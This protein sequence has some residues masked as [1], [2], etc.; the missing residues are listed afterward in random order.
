[1]IFNHLLMFEGQK[2][3][4]NHGNFFLQ[5]ESMYQCMYSIVMRLHKLF[6]ISIPEIFSK[7]YPEYPETNP[8][9]IECSINS[10]KTWL[11]IVSGIIK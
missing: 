10:S 4:W 5:S 11:K 6:S 7:I 3:I 1:M 2:K 8:N 9:I